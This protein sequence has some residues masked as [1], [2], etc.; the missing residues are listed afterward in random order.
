MLWLLT[1]GMLGCD[2][3]T[4]IITD[5][6]RTLY[7]EDLQREGR[8]V[9]GDAL[10]VGS[11][12]CMGMDTESQNDCVRMSGLDAEPEYG[13]C[14]EFPELGLAEVE[15]EPMPC[16]VDSGWDTK[17]EEPD[18]L[19]LDVIPPDGLN[20]VLS[21]P[22][23][24]RAA[25]MLSD[26]V[27]EILGPEFA[28]E[29]VVPSEEVALWVWPDATLPVHLSLYAGEADV[30][31]GAPWRTQVEGAVL[32]EEAWTF[33][34]GEGGRIA[35]VNTAGEGRIEARE[36]MPADINAAIEDRLHLAIGE[37]E[38]EDFDQLLQDGE[39]PLPGIS[40]FLE[41]TGPDGEV[42]K[43]QPVTWSVSGVW[44][45]RI[46]EY[47]DPSAAEVDLFCAMNWRSRRERMVLHA[48]TQNGS[49]KQSFWVRIPRMPR[50]AQ[51]KESFKEYC[52]ALQ[53][54]L[55]GCS[56]V[57][58]RGLLLPGLLGLLGLLL[59]RKQD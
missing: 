40:A 8:F 12:F 1:L 30:A 59:R 56:Q 28:V 54:E 42:V 2:T 14:F 45:A 58:G 33:N 23:E 5:G 4:R 36:W 17:W 3:R 43:G 53:P 27:Y 37:Y 20:A 48:S 47:T 34:G 51:S 41:S 13:F 21:W 7:S 44:G 15:I 46:R 10:L 32:E 9:S 6:E 52:D 39:S 25:S 22:I 55:S 50:D 26:G 49:Y 19:R 11:S 35:V 16:E 57:P 31:W 38:K 18:L 24:A 29:G